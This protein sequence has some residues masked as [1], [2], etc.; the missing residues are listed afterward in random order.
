VVH[1]AEV[2]VPGRLPPS[3]LALRRVLRRAAIVIAAGRYPLAEAERAAGRPLPATSVP[4]GVD[5]ERF[6]PIDEAERATVR[7]ELGLPTDALVVA[8]ISR[9]VPRKGFDVL[10]RAAAQLRSQH[11]DL[12]VAIGGGGRDRARLERIA[13]ETDA[14]ARFVG[15]IADSLLP[16]AYAASDV[17]AMLCRNRWAGLE[18]EGFGIV[19]LEAAAAGVPQVAGR[20]GGSDEAVLDGITGFVVDDPRDPAAVAAALGWLL[21]DPERRADMGEASRER[22]VASFGH[23]HLADRLQ[24]ALDGVQQ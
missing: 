2:T 11:P 6:H 10:L 18:Q 19:F 5:G 3:M 15:R 9:L 13:R 1:G 23:D 16:G 20:S 14:P 12:V 22:A 7:R 8:G 17:Y 21:D 4:P 24:A